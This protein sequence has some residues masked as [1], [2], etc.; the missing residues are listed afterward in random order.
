M[1]LDPVE[2][3]RGVEGGPHQQPRPPGEPEHT[4]VRALRPLEPCFLFP[5]LP[6]PLTSGLATFACPVS[7]PCSWVLTMVS[8]SLLCSLTVPQTFHL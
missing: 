3:S 4:A 1:S 7:V 8:P 2:K 5:L 6:E